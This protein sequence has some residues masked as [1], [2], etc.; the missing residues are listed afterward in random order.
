MFGSAARPG[1]GR[2]IGKEKD[3]RMLA[4]ETRPL[5]AIKRSGTDHR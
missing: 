5:A 4:V 2:E 3:R 1:I